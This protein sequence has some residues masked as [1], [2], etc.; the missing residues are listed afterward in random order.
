MEEV[1]KEDIH[2]KKSSVIGRFK[3]ILGKIKHTRSDSNAINLILQLNFT[4]SVIE[5][6][7]RKLNHLLREFRA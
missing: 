3:R 1:V 4:T 2:I 6:A 5:A 7:V